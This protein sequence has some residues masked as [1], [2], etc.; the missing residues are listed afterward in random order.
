MKWSKEEDNMLR[1]MMKEKISFI[2]RWRDYH[3]KL[4]IVVEVMKDN[5]PS[6]RNYTKSSVRCRARRLK[7]KES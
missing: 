3:T 2:P 1:R 7:E 5:F 6:R 4:W